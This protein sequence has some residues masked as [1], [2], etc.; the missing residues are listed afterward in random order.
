MES[1]FLKSIRCKDALPGVCDRIHGRTSKK[2]P[3]DKRPKGRSQ[4][5]RHEVLN[6]GTE[7]SESHCSGPS[8]GV[9]PG[10]LLTCLS[11]SE[12]FRKVPSYPESQNAEQIG[13]I[14]KV[15]DGFNIFSKKPPVSRVLYGINR[16]TRCL[17]PH[18]YC[19]QVAEISEVSTERRE[20]GGTSAIQSTPVWSVIIP[21]GLHENNGRSSGASASRGDLSY[22]LSGRS[23]VF[24]PDQRRS[25]RKLAQSP[26]SSRI[27][28]VDFK[29]SKIK[30]DS[31][32]GSVIPGFPYQLFRA[33]SFSSRGKAE[34]VGTSGVIATVQSSSVHQEGYVSIG[35]PDLFHSGHPVGKA[36]FQTSAK[37]PVKNL[38]SPAGFTRFISE[39]PYFSK[40]KSVVVEEPDKVLRG[41]VMVLPN[42]GEVDNRCQFLGLG[43][44]YERPVGP[45]LVGHKRCPEVLKLEGTKSYR[46][47]LTDLCER[48][49]GATYS[50]P[51]R[52]RHGGGLHKQTG[53]N[54]KQSSAELGKRHSELG[55]APYSILIRGPF[56]RDPKQSSGLPKQEPDFRGRV[57]IESRSLP[58]NS[59]EM[60]APKSGSLCHPG[61]LANV[62][63]LLPGQERD[64]TGSGCSGARLEVSPLLRIPPVS[65]YPSGHSKNQEG[66]YN[67]D[68][69]PF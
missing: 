35:N 60:G 58:V 10:V 37:F 17:P 63:L 21:K 13:R 54:Q 42:S 22:S 56:K 41:A 62:S 6:S 51:V 67:S 64:I 1:H 19:R 14:Q 34:K 3:G 40:K 32:T 29:P 12:T 25:S 46:N 44:S 23:A 9:L 18:S 28:G 45:G 8:G 39:D 55:R 47:G 50:D 2:I 5:S 49:P 20:E 57:A 43:G 4:G 7:K 38:E 15:S 68:I 26:C 66:G 48:S 27:H 61:K 59:A 16:F 52:Q 31:L 36:P 33:K 11:G 53:G 30:S 69:T 65:A 24:C